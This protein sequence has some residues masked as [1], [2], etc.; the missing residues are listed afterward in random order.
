MK[1]RNEKIVGFVDT[2]YDVIELIEDNVTLSRERKLQKLNKIKKDFFLVNDDSNR[3]IYNFYIS[4]SHELYMLKNNLGEYNDKIANNKDLQVPE[5]LEYRIADLFNNDELYVYLLDEDKQS[6]NELVDLVNPLLHKIQTHNIL[7][8]IPEKQLQYENYFKDLVF[9]AN[10]CC[11]IL[12]A[13]EI[14]EQSLQD[15]ETKSGM[16]KST[17]ILSL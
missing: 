8:S 16:F 14:L 7:S 1:I 6:Y 10:N 17:E 13:K 12:E 9:N 3:E 4:I 2:F 5:L 11:Q 15:I